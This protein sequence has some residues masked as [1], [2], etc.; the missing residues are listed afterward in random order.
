MT[1]LRNNYQKKGETLNSTHISL[2]FLLLSVGFMGCVS[3]KSTPEVAAE[4]SNS[5]IPPK[6]YKH[7]RAQQQ[8]FQTDAGKIAFTDHGTGHALVLI[9][10]VPTSSWM[11]RKLIP[12]L[13]KNY[14][15]IT[16][17]L[18]GYGSSEKPKEDAEKYSHREQA[19]RVLQL[20]SAR[21]IS[22]F[23]LLF[24]D[25]G[26]L[27]A[28]E[29]LEAAP[30]R[31][32]NLIVLNTIVDDQGFNQPKLGGK[33]MV[34]QITKAYK[35]RITSAA[36]IKTTLGHLGLKGDHKLTEDECYGYVKPMREGANHALYSFF[37]SI[38]KDLFSNLQNKQKKWPQFSGD[39]M[40]LWGGKDSILTKK[41]IPILR[42]SF[43]IPSQRI[44]I[45]KNNAHFLAEEIPDEVTSKIKGF[46]N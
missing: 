6:D 29:M 26:G 22:N 16:V 36:I 7:H 15:V 10:G 8:H 39:V 37:T 13:Q 27:V 40:V 23:S 18:L 20:V 42:K 9:H 25:M 34:S 28:W 5:Y 14:R 38:N 45:Y 3:K 4:V 35:S 33:F 44:H 31:L 17:D 1:R 2:Y 41:Q 11:Y 21:G 30:S 46:L 43:S 24:H 19:R 12:K 32:K